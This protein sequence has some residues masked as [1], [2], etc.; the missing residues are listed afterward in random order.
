MRYQLALCGVLIIYF[1]THNIL[2]ALSF[3]IA[4]VPVI[5]AII[6]PVAT[7]IGI[8]ILAKQGILVKSSPSLENLTK[9]N[10]F[11]F[12]K[13]GTI[14]QGKPEV[15]EIIELGR[16]TTDILQLA[17]SIETYSNH[18]LA[19]PILEAAKDKKVKLLPLKN[20][21]TFVGQGMTGSGHSFTVFLGNNALLQRLTLHISKAVASTVAQWEQKGATPVFVGINAKLIGII[22]LLD[23]LKPEAK[24]LFLQLSQRGYEAIIV[25]GDKREVAHT[26]TKELQGASFIA[27]VTPEGKVDEVNKKLREGKNIVMIGD[28]IN[29]APAL[30]KAQVGIAMGGRGVDLTLNAADIVLL[31]NNIASIPTMV[32][33]SKK[34]FRIIKQDVLLA[35]SIHVIAAILVIIGSI[36]L[37]E[38]TIIHEISSAL[39]LVNT[40]RIFRVVSS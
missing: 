29:D 4:V 28:G 21:K 24:P 13:T 40:L 17:A 12:D 2:Q 16:S 18:P 20:V 30:A 15:A 23:K 38:T 35:T 11:L 32:A 8:T 36:S 22:F 27:D 25:T 14:T 39:V 3:W 10:T 19:I 26:I 7:T 1:V 9:A 37:V 31:N 34:T 33:V 5:F 6:V